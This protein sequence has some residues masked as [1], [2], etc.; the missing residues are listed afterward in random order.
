MLV[1]LCNACGIR[2]RLSQG[3][4]AKQHKKSLEAAAEQQ[5]I[6]QQH[7]TS[8]QLLGVQPHHTQN[9]IHQQGLLEKDTKSVANMSSTNHSGNC[10]NNGVGSAVAAAVS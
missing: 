8:S 10:K 1:R 2:W 9:N 3:E 7:L 4:V 6:F 5:Q